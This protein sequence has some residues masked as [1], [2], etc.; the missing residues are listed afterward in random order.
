M[1][2]DILVN[3]DINFKKLAY[4]G[5]SNH[6][7]LMN[8]CMSIEQL[9]ENCDDKTLL[10]NFCALYYLLNKYSELKEN[11]DILA[12][13]DDSIFESSINWM[14]DLYNIFYEQKECDF[15][16]I[17]NGGL[18]LFFYEN[19]ED[20][21]TRC[22]NLENNAIKIDIIWTNEEFVT[23]HTKIPLFDIIKYTFKC[24][25][26]ILNLCIIFDKKVI[27]NFIES[28][29]EVSIS[30]NLEVACSNEHS[31]GYLRE[32]SREIKLGYYTANAH[33]DNF[34]CVVNKF[35]LSFICIDIMALS[36]MMVDFLHLIKCKTY[37]YI[38]NSKNERNFM[39]LCNV[40]GIIT[41]CPLKELFN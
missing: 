1:F 10:R 2:E 12:V 15:Y 33:E 28:I 21:I 24:K 32:L 29:K 4:Y 7:F 41:D 13:F 31:L 6:R 5:E 11:S 22:M 20:A 27:E 25:H 16:F 14:K 9:D 36:P 17:A 40:D 23:K 38:G 26:L 37:S 3:G 19:S 39:K 30:T 18:S 8:V 35:E 34:R